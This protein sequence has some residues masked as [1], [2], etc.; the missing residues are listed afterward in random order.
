MLDV[1]AAGSRA[2]ANAGR[3]RGMV[4]APVALWTRSRAAAAD[5][6]TIATLGVPSPVLMERAALCCAR[7]A[8]AM[9][10]ELPVWILCGPGNNGGDGVAVARILHGWGVRAQACL[11]SER[12][13]AEL[14]QQ[15]AL[16]QRI[17]VTVVRGLPEETCEA[18]IV[19]AMLGTGAAPPLREPFVAAVAWANGRPG[20][21]LAIDV[22]TGID[23]DTGAVPGLAFRADRT[24]TFVRSKPGLH[25]TPGRGWA[26]EVMVAEI[27][28]VS[29]D[30]SEGICLIDPGEVARAIARLRP[31][32]HKGE[33]G[34]VGI[35][36]GSSGTPGAAVI[37]GAAALRGG[38]GLVTI[39]SDDP[40]VQGQLLAHR[41]ELMVQGRGARPVAAAGVLVVGPGLVRAEDRAGLTALWREDPRPAVWDASAL[42]ESAERA[43]AGRVITP[44]PAEAGRLLSARTGE[45]WSTARVQSDRMAAARALVTATGA[46]V[47]LKG[48][49]TLVAGEAGLAV[50]VSGGPAL[51]TA[52]SG[53]CLAGL[54]GA[55][56]GRGLSPWAAACAG[57]HVHGV[58]GER[59][60]V[61]AMALE[62]ADATGEVLAAPPEEHPRYPR[63]V[64]G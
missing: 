42:S 41:P 39:A 56:I 58:A 31:G 64:L 28:I 44:H 33:R 26:G 13:G 25:V 53:D 6:H 3:L 22:P 46:V 14:Q 27:G 10:G 21:R 15:V 29:E 19:D 35:V 59:L 4:R 9:C 17:G 8:L 62:I 1:T 36:G 30:M 32:A 20:P 5:Q 60:A 40:L 23:A 38:A 54:I 7:E 61:G 37:A 18:L 47:V 63:R 52:G 16:A 11:L 43:T 57:V 24:V 49:G 45:S 2:R 12:L 50:C 34:H 51:A 55:L 48:E